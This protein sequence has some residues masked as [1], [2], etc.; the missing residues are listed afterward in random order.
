MG[1]Q[2]DKVSSHEK[3]SRWQPA[4]RRPKADRGDSGTAAKGGPSPFPLGAQGDKVY[5]HK[6]S[7]L[8]RLLFLWELLDSNQ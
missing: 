6:K 7:N 3:S 8:Q 5:S 2:G 4:Y 1:A